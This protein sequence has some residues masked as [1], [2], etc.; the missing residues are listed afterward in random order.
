MG[1]IKVNEIV[2]ERILEICR[3]NPNMYKTQI[4]KN[5]GEIIVDEVHFKPT[6]SKVHNNIKIL[7]EQGRLYQKGRYFECRD[8]EHYY[9]LIPIIKQMR[10][11]GKSQGEIAEELN[12]SLD[13]VDNVLK[14]IAQKEE[15]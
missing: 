7:L 10:M 8:C 1:T 12:I 3:N 15:V 5:I 14:E 11:A 6:P 9:Q 2:Q 13:N 4:A